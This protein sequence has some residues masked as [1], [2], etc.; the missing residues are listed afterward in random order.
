[1]NGTALV[2]Q[3]AHPLRTGDRVRIGEVE[4]EVV[5]A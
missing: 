5:S 4:I 1:V 3:Q 2:A